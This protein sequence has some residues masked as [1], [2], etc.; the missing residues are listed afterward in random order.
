MTEVVPS[1][2]GRLD[3]V[4][5]T[6]RP[7]E[8]MHYISD[9]QLA[10]LGQM[11]HE[12]VMEIFLLSAGAFLGSVVPAFQE[13][14]KFGAVENAMNQWGLFTCLLCAMCL[15]VAVVTGLL[16]RGR[17]RSHVNMVEEIR[18]RP[19]RLVTDL[20]RAERAPTTPA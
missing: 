14:G 16:W 4:E 10:R 9:E 18:G 11:R 19:K 7:S 17:L 12:P 6:T 5:V 8:L 13:A 2:T 3:V 20:A 1:F 15:S